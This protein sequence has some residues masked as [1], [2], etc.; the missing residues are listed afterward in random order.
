MWSLLPHV[1]F[2]IGESKTVIEYK[3]YTVITDDSIIVIADF[4]HLALK[5]SICRRGL[6]CPFPLLP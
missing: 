5:E 4:E 2:L 3:K 1:S 6:P